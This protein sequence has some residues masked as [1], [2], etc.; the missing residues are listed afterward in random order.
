MNRSGVESQEQ[1]EKRG[2]KKTHGGEGR[3]GV[4]ILLIVTTLV[5]L[6]LYLKQQLA[7]GNSFEWPQFGGEERI[8][9]EK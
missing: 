9:I 4:L 8:T 1:E 3:K 6:A 7:K 2:K 5:S